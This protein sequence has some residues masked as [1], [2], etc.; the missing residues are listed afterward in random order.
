MRK[1]FDGIDIEQAIRIIKTNQ[2]VLGF[3]MNTKLTLTMDKELIEQAKAHAAAQKVSLSSYIAGF[4]RATTAPK[5]EDREFDRSKL[6]P[7]AR[8]ALGML[9]SPELA[10]M[11]YKEMLL[12]ALEEKYGLQ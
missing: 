4:L 12:E 8:R 2:H 9:S 3:A 11:E 10:K 7:V 6:S 5:K 1:C